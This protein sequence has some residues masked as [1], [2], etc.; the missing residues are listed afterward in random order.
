M[1]LDTVLKCAQIA[2]DH[3]RAAMGYVDDDILELLAELTP[4]AVVQEV[5]QVAEPVA[6]PVEEP[7]E[8]APAE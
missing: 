2:A 7:A 8:D 1:N 6:E 5:V 3:R 4:A